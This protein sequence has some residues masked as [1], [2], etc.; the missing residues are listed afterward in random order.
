M[1]VVRPAVPLL[2]LLTGEELREC[3][4]H[5][6]VARGGSRSVLSSDRSKRQRK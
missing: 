3:A 1:T 2:E 5:F 4:G 6:D